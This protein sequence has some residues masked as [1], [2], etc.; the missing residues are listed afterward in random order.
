MKTETIE[1][2]TPEERIPDDDRDL[3]VIIGDYWIEAKYQ[4]D[5]WTQPEWGPIE[6]IPSFWCYKPKGP[7]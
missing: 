4:W 2:F 1:W 7:R 3:L 5:H 6:E